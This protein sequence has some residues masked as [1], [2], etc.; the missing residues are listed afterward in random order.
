[1]ICSVVRLLGIRNR[2]CGFRST[3]TFL[4]LRNWGL[5]LMPVPVTGADMTRF[6]TKDSVARFGAVLWPEKN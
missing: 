3:K 1:M 2:D 4:F 6:F 5:Q